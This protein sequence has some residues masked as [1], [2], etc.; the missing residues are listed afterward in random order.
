MAANFHRSLIVHVGQRA[1]SVICAC[2]CSLSQGYEQST[3]R[4]LTANALKRSEVWSDSSRLDALYLSDEYSDTKSILLANMMKG[5]DEEDNGVR[6]LWHFYN[7]LSGEGLL[8]VFT[9]SPNWIIPGI[10]NV[11]YSYANAVALYYAALTS[12]TTEARSVQAE[13][14]G[15]NLGH[16]LHHV[17]DMAQPQH[18]RNDAHC[19]ADLCYKSGYGNR[20]FYELGTDRR[21]RECVLNPLA[22]QCGII[23]SDDSQIPYRANLRDPLFSK[24]WDFWA[25]IL[26]NADGLS[27]GLASITNS[28]FVSQGTN[29]QSCNNNQIGIC[30]P[31]GFANPAPKDMRRETLRI[32]ISFLD[33]SIELTPIVG[34]KNL[35]TGK[36][37]SSYNSITGQYFLSDFNDQQANEYLLPRAIAYSAGLLNF[38]FR[39]QIE[40]KYSSGNVQIRNIGADLPSGRL[41]LLRDDS[42][43]IRR[44]VATWTDLRI[45]SLRNGDSI[46]AP[47]TG[48][49]PGSYV[50]I[51]RPDLMCDEQ[52]ECRQDLRG[53]ALVAG[54]RFFVAPPPPQ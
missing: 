26:D 19:S 15:Q 20:S 36:Y 11:A 16:V 28:Q 2:S 35:N 1:L 48:F 13:R 53:G 33:G 5:A 34:V 46:T 18:T 45:S 30:A 17:Q 40:A 39:G 51:F 54:A 24:A 50:M 32:A 14:L 4:T 42:Q 8:G 41:E 38:F 22:P 43:G 25:N 49:T 21:V 27:S 9:S 7:P 44:R 31:Q 23:Q 47:M 3:H 6:P 10:S 12:N 52:V 29:F 37:I